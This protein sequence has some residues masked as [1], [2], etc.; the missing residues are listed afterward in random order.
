MRVLMI[1]DHVSFI[2]GLEMLLR[3]MA[4]QIKA[5]L[6]ANLAEAE[7][8]LR[9]GPYELVLLDWHLPG[10]MGDHSMEFLRDRG[11]TAPIV[12]L[13]GET[14]TQVIESAIDRG[15]VGFIPKAYTSEMMVS[16]LEQVLVGQIFLPSEAAPPTSPRVGDGDAKSYDA[17]LAELTPRQLAVYMAATRGLSNKL[18]ARELGV[19]AST[20]KSHLS[21][22]YATLGVRNR[23]EAAYQVSQEGRQYFPSLR[24]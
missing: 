6:A 5:S 19:E 20:V 10:A 8:F 18:I 16:A 12:V 22:I 15:A 7:Q 1:D 11:C 13:S 24:R 14:S 21:A 2:E 23:T 9:Q 3:V 17:R 4:P